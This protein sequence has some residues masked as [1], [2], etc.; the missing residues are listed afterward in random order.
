MV[1]ELDGH[2]RK[3]LRQHEN[4]TTSPARRDPRVSL[5]HF[6]VACSHSYFAAAKYTSI[7]SKTGHL[8]WDENI[9]RSATSPHNLL[10]A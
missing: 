5:S 10:A 8:L 3:E 1:V 4:N 2:R 6:N 7:S 9:L